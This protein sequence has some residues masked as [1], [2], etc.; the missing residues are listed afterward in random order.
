M[1]LIY[2]EHN[3]YMNARQQQKKSRRISVSFGMKKKTFSWYGKLL[4]YY[5]VVFCVELVCIE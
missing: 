3:V 4:Q 2:T 5:T 1:K